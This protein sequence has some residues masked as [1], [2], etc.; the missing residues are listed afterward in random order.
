MGV[1]T[2]VSFLDWP[3]FAEQVVA[4][5]KRRSGIELLSR[6]L[7]V[8]KSLVSTHPIQYFVGSVLKWTVMSDS[9]VHFN[10]L[11]IH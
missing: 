10:T 6:I 2:R 3:M 8:E 5:E 4:N 11:P 9:F 7:L 1:L